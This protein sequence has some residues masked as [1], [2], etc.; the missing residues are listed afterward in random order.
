[1]VKPKDLKKGVVLISVGIN[2]DENN[3]LHGDYDEEAIK[4]IAAYFTP[5]PGGVGPVN[6][7]ILMENLLTAAERQTK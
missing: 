3:K 5:T 4:D 6:V 2:R 7:A 1:M